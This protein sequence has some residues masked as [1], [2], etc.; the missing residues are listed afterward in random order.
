[1]SVFELRLKPYRTD[2]QADRRARR[3]TQSKCYKYM[4]VFVR[5]GGVFLPQ[6]ARPHYPNAAPVSL[7]VNANKLRVGDV[8]LDR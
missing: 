3:V 2:G 6:H 1:L 8:L 7:R 4:C 5:L